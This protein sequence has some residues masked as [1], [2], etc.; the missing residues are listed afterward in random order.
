MGGEGHPEQGDQRG[1]GPPEGVERSGSEL[2]RSRAIR[3]VQRWV[4]S[5]LV[6]V[7][8][9]GVIFR[10]CL[11][12]L[13]PPEADRRSWEMRAMVVAPHSRWLV[14]NTTGSPV[15]GSSSSARRR[16][17]GRLAGAPLGD[18]PGPPRR[19]GDRIGLQPGHEAEPLEGEGGEPGAVRVAPVDDQ[20]GAGDEAERLGRPDLM[21]PLLGDPGEAAARRPIEQ[22]GAEIDHRGGRAEERG[23]EPEPAA[24]RGDRLGAVI[25]QGLSF[26]SQV[27]RPL[28]TCL[29]RR[30]TGLPEGMGA[31]PLA[32]QPGDAL[33]PAG[34]ARGMAFGSGLLHRSL[35]LHPG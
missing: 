4:C 11:S 25:P 15:S 8:T 10:D 9:K 7:P 30:Q 32:E 34:E 14:R 29:C 18:L 21:L 12:A 33:A 35:K 2:R 13:N 3:A 28:Q 19:R 26:P 23:L 24:T 6:L 20:D 17:Y 1:Q 5:A 22:A 31:A 27:A 16:G